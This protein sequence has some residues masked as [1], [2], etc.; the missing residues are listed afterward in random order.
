MALEK[1][2]DDQ[3]DVHPP[4]TAH[5]FLPFPTG[6]SQSVA[7]GSIVRLLARFVIRRSYGTAGAAD[8][9]VAWSCPQRARK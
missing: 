3:S 2:R 1:G 6:H 7:F 4:V 8:Y 5:G 9:G